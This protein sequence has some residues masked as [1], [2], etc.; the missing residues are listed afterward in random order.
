MVYEGLV[1]FAQSTRTGRSWGIR[2]IVIVSA[3]ARVYDAFVRIRAPFTI[4]T[5]RRIPSCH[6]PTSSMITLQPKSPPRAKKPE[7]SAQSARV[8]GVK[9]PYPCGTISIFVRPPVGLLT[10]A[11]PP[12]SKRN[13][14]GLRKRN[15]RRSEKRL[16]GKSRGLERKRVSRN[17]ILTRPLWVDYPN[18]DHIAPNQNTAQRITIA[19]SP[20][21]PE[22]GMNLLRVIVLASVWLSS[23]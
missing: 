19:P 17:L 18:A 7:P 9:N 2:H 22:G 11:Q 6:N 14:H 12:K 16:F 23:A 1:I 20:P 5:N 3:F 21:R 13:A 8:S 10:L 4:T 15:G